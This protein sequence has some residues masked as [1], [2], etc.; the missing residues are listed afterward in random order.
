[1]TTE[2]TDNPELS[3]YEVVVDGRPAGHA[4]Y[5][6]RGDQVVFTHT[7]V[8][9]DFE[10]QGVGSALARGALDDVRAKGR[11]VVPRCPF[12][13]AWIDKHPQY[14]DLVVAA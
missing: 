8:S 6:L 3:R 14:G 5:V 12:I 1:M 4:E 9:S 11:T 2:V 7:E 10:G 13:R